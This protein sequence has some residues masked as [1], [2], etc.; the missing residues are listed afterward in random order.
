MRTGQLLDRVR[1][2]YVQ[3]FCETVA[4]LQKQPRTKVLTEVALRNAAGEVACEGELDLPMRLDA[5]AVKDGNESRTIYIDS[6]ERLSFQAFVFDWGGTLRVMLKPFQW[7]SLQ[8]WLDQP[9]EAEGYEPMKA[10][11]RQWFRVDEDGDG[12][13]LGVVHFLSDP[14]QLGGGTMFQVDIGTAPVQSFEDMLDAIVALKVPD[15]VIG[16]DQ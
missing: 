7:D 13:P 5:V 11:F 14:G 3:A 4:D 10:W 12:K 9:P 1:G 16:T 8:L 6:I 15:V 2:H